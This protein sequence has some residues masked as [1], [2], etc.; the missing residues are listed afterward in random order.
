MM[1]LNL[2][3][4]ILRY[5]WHVVQNENGTGGVMLVGPISAKML[6]SI[7]DTGR[8]RTFNTGVHSHV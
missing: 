6:E 8:E 7:R 1:P 5:A 4:D 3:Y 2:I